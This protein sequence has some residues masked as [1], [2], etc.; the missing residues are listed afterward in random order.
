MQQIVPRSFCTRTYETYNVIQ[1]YLIKLRRELTPSFL[2]D[3]QRLAE[4]IDMLKLFSGF[5]PPQVKEVEKLIYYIEEELLYT[6][7]SEFQQF[8][9][10]LGIEQFQSTNNN[11]T[12]IKNIIENC[13]SSWNANTIKL[14]LSLYPR[15]PLIQE[16]IH[17]IASL[18]SQI[19]TTKSDE[20]TYKKLINQFVNVERI[21]NIVH[22]LLKDKDVSQA[23][24]TQLSLQSFST[25]LKGEGS[26]EEIIRP[27]ILGEELLQSNQIKKLKKLLI[28]CLKKIEDS[29]VVT[30]KFPISKTSLEAQANLHKTI[31]AVKARYSNMRIRFK[32]LN[33]SSNWVV[34]LVARDAVAF[35]KENK[36]SKPKNNELL[37]EFMWD[38]AVIMELEDHFVATAS[39]SITKKPF[40]YEMNG[41]VK[42]LIWNKMGTKLIKREV[43]ARERKAGS[44]QPQAGITLDENF[45]Q[46]N[47][48][49]ISRE[50]LIKGTLI[51]ILMGFLDAKRDNIL[52]N[53][54]GKIK[55]FD[56]ARSLPHS[57]GCT[58]CGKNLWSSFR[59][60]LIGLSESHVILTP[61]DR[62][63]ITTETESY[64]EKYNA[65]K[66]FFEN[67]FTLSKIKR[68]PE[69]TLCPRDVL[70][71]MK[72]RINLLEAGID[73]PGIKT[74]CELSLA[75]QPNLRFIVAISYFGATYSIDKN[76]TDFLN[77]AGEEAI[78]SCIE[79]CVKNGYDPRV[80]KDISDNPNLSFKEMME[81]INSLKPNN[82]PYENDIFEFNAKILIKELRKSAK[83]DNKE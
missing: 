28:T 42:K 25:S 43:L 7:E 35:Y 9:S 16:A 64:K 66:K 39:T 74:L 67:E 50:E 4:N 69:G 44:I 31:R 55:F 53:P 22:R 58:L 78:D 82:D 23:A 68:L 14:L 72:E 47:P 61:E 6:S 80:I 2:F 71:A 57:N 56:N 27:F 77:V 36:L 59:S 83:I 30:P 24:I 33:V 70:H 60:G 54:D 76:L 3:L 15:I 49:P 12:E 18:C 45:S 48:I 10:L 79:S 21:V 13:L 51:S 40:A 29:T 52:I 17:E 20:T 62:Q 46:P 65:L 19:V 81:T 1:N 34:K 75:S 37:E 63:L 8:I 38:C 11:L 26:L 32:P 41:R 5:E 73:D